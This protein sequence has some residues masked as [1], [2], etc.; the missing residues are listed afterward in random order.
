MK[1]KPSKDLCGCKCDEHTW[2][3]ICAQHKKEWGAVHEQWQED[4]KKSMKEFLKF[5]EKSAPVL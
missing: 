2:I 4:R 5:C 3:K 1:P